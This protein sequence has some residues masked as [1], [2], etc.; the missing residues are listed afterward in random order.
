MMSEKLTHRGP[1]DK[2]D[3]D[4]D[5]VSL[6]F[7]RLSILDIKNGNYDEA[8]NKLEKII[9]TDPDFGKAYNHLG[10][11]Y[12]VKFKEYEKGETQCLLIRSFPVRK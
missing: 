8:S 6:G 4:N 9:D 11:L 10:Y 7:K 2:G 1:D 12:E 5:F 3:F